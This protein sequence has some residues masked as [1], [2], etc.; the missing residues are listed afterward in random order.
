[1]IADSRSFGFA[2]DDKKVQFIFEI[3]REDKKSPTYFE[4][5]QDGS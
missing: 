4:I 3:I 2:Q 1:M 5:I